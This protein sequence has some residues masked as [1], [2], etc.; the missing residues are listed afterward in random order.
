MP[1]QQDLYNFVNSGARPSTPLGLTPVAT[2]SAKGPGKIWDG[3]FLQDFFD[4]LSLPSYALGQMAAGQDV[5]LSGTGERTTLG[6]VLTKDMTPGLLQGATS[7]GVTAV[8]DPVNLFGGAIAKAGLKGVGLLP[9]GMEISEWVGRG[10]KAGYRKATA[11]EKMQTLIHKGLNSK[12]GQWLESVDIPLTEETANARRITR[13]LEVKADKPMR[14]LALRIA[15][16][17]NTSGVAKNRPLNT[18]VSEY[19]GAGSE[20]RTMYETSKWK[21]A[22]D[23]AGQ[24]LL[25][26]AGETYKSVL[27]LDDMKSN[28]R[29]A[30]EDY[31]RSDAWRAHEAAGVKQE[32]VLDTFHKFSA[33]ANELGRLAMG[34]RIKQGFDKRLARRSFDAWEDYHLKRIFM[35]QGDLKHIDNMI[36]GVSLNADAHL[37]AHG[38]LTKWAEAFGNDL[39]EPGMV[40]K[41]ADDYLKLLLDERATIAAQ[42]ARNADTVRTPG[43]IRTAAV[44]DA[45][46]NLTDAQIKLYEPIHATA[47][48]MGINAA[49]VLHSV[50]NDHLY[51]SV[52]ENFGVRKTIIPGEKAAYD[53]PYSFEIPAEY[54]DVVTQVEV[55]VKGRSKK[56]AVE[57]PVTI[58]NPPVAPVGNAAT[59]PRYDEWVAETDRLFGEQGYQYRTLAKRRASRF[60]SPQDMDKAETLMYN[61]R[62]KLSVPFKEKE[63]LVE[64]ESAAHPMLTTDGKPIVH[65]VDEA[66]LPHQ[67]IGTKWSMLDD[68]QRNVK[69]LEADVTGLKEQGYD[70]SSVDYAVKE[71][72][73]RK[74]V[75]GEPADEYADIKTELWDD[76]VRTI[77]E[78]DGSHLEAPKVPLTP[79]EEYEQTISSV[80]SWKTEQYIN[81]RATA[82]NKALT[83]TERA[84]GSNKAADMLSKLSDD[85]MAKVSQAEERLASRAA[86]PPTTPISAPAPKTNAAA[87]KMRTKNVTTRVEKQPAETFTS[88]RR[89][90]TPATKDRVNYNASADDML[91]K[92]NQGLGDVRYSRKVMSR[93]GDEALGIEPISVGD[94]YFGEF[95]RASDLVDGKIPEDMNPQSVEWS[96]ALDDMAAMK[97]NAPV[98][99]RKLIS[100]LERQGVKVDK[101]RVS[102][103][104]AEYKALGSNAIPEPRPSAVP[105]DPIYDSWKARDNARKVATGELQEERRRI[106]EEL[107]QEVR[108]G[109][110]HAIPVEKQPYLYGAAAA[111]RLNSALLAKEATT[112]KAFYK[113]AYMAMPK[114]ESWGAL[115]EAVVPRSVGMMLVNAAREP[116][117]YL[118]AMRVIYQPWK[119]GVI[120]LNPGVH[121]RNFVANAMLAHWNGGLP[122]WRL[123]VYAK[124]F[125]ETMAYTLW[126]KGFKEEMP[127]LEYISSKELPGHIENAIQ[128]LEFRDVKSA[129][130]MEQKVAKMQRMGGGSPTMRGVRNLEK[131]AG[132]VAETMTDAYAFS[133]SWFKHAVYIS[134]RQKGVAA[135]IAAERATKA[136]FDYQDV[137]HLLSYVR[138]AG[139]I[140]FPTF[141]YKMINVMGKMLAD[142]PGL[143]NIYGNYVPRGIEKALQADDPAAKIAERKKVQKRFKRSSAQPL[144]IGRG[145]YINYSP[146]TPYAASID[147]ATS[148]MAM[149]TNPLWQT[150]TTLATNRDQYGREVMK[151]AD[152]KFDQIKAAMGYVV[153]QAVPAQSRMLQQA[154]EGNGPA[155][156]LGVSSVDIYE[157][158][159]QTKRRNSM[160]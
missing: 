153:S 147:I 111:D 4:T 125:N 158:K 12:F 68:N 83:V 23:D 102:E 22:V 127:E 119:V 56:A 138:S 11:G 116:D 141:S 58:A 38:G 37:E 114:D 42:T 57:E 31:F 30:Q 27:T 152:S 21:N 16:M 123:D 150:G 63:A 90:V 107:K 98:A 76:I 132:G 33:P 97:K 106:F 36:Q 55:P 91:N 86:P 45:R 62:T 61:M 54:E 47:E 74:K 53:G 18:A 108:L 148:P 156:V 32:D 144:R 146:F 101:A 26:D 9:E 39:T 130:E 143:L 154:M 29:Q 89:Q 25:D 20:W 35:H 137:P 99:I 7:F 85:A 109:N 129:A 120:S 72:K 131:A 88:P 19:M 44:M 140:P 103:L 142:K 112:G 1:T 155:G 133:E 17:F 100:K 145:R 96:K 34:L 28:I 64:L 2:P 82:N 113:E 14:E 135:D 40:S 84:V 105:G 124:A 6:D 51:R 80:F 95:K 81:A 43:G 49:E 134:L 71:F 104:V 78:L 128:T 46:R 117:G 79:I 24:E 69:K 110:E 136:L 77:D 93:E 160:R 67:T 15:N 13:I 126:K 65:N 75:A 122:P 59:P 10:V 70:T 159:R 3:G 121:I 149:L 41:T 60:T 118:K 66:E 48:Q 73:A 151:A 157:K 92:T 87:P 8:T 115:S 94:D 52:L 50:R 139:L 5:N